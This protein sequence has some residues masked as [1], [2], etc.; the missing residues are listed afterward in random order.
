VHDEF[1]S[2]VKLAQSDY[3]VPHP[4]AVSLYEWAG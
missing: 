3:H 1:P 2:L 4:D